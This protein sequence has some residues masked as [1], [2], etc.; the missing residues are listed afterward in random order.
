MTS[1]AAVSPAPSPESAI[2]LERAQDLAA[3]TDLSAR[4]F[5]PGRFA[6]TAYRVREGAPPV[7]ELCLTAWREERLVGA[8]RFTAV[9]VGETRAALLLGPLAVEPAHAGKGHGRALIREGLERARGLGY[10]LVVLVGDLP[11]YAR[12]G[13][14]AVPPGQIVLPGPA[15][16]ARI[17]AFEL[18]PGALAQ[19][20]GALRAAGG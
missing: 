10:R 18:E 16:P 2:R 14:V 13:F 4:A 1:T 19:Y 3:I 20:R 12:V 11:Y 7:P 5:G 15:D 9:T 8:I 17:L 6:R